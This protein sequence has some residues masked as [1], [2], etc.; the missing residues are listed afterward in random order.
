MKYFPFALPI[1]TFLLFVSS[2]TPLQSGSFPLTIEDDSG[3]DGPW[4]IVAG[5][6]FPEGLTK[7][8]SAMRIISGGREVP[9]QMDVAATW[10]DGSIRW[11]LAGFTASPQ[12]QYSVEYGEGVK[13]GEYPNPL[14]VI[15]QD[16][17]GF[18]VD[19]GAAVYRFESD[20]ILPEEGWIVIAGRREKILDGSGAGVYLV[21]NK[22]RTARIAGEAAEVK[23]EFLK[24]GPGRLVLKRSGWYVTD[25]GEKLARADVWLYF[26]SGV[27]Y[28]RAT[29]TLVF[30]EDTNNVWFKDYGLEFKTPYSPLQ[31][32]CAVGEN[33]KEIHKIV[34]SGDE[35]YLLQAEYPHFAEREY[36]AAI[37]SMKNGQDSVMEEIKEVGDWAYGDY[38][39]YGISIVMPWLAERYPKEIS[40]GRRGARAVFWSGRS[41][42]E[43]DFR[44]KT[45][46]EEYWQSWAEKGPGSPG[47]GKLSAF[48]SNAAGSARTHDIWFL[49]HAGAYNEE[50]VKK[51]ALAGSRQ[52]LAIAN[53]VWLCETEAMGYPMLHKDTERFPKQEAMISECWQRYMIPYKAFPLTGFIEW[54]DFSTWQYNTVGGRI[55]AQFHILTNIDR[56]SSRREPWRLFARSAERQYYNYGHRFSRFS[57]DWY[58]IHHDVAN[59]PSRNRGSFMSFTPEGGRL[60][61]AWG[62]TGHL[63]ITNGGDIGC[64]L[65]E[66]Y[67]T[68]DERS[69]DLL[70]MIKESFKKYWKVEHAIG[71]NQ[72]K[73]VRELVTLSIMDWDEDAVKMAKEVADSMF[74][75]ESQ[76][77]I[78][79][80]RDSYGTMYKDHRTSHNTAEYYLE[81]KDELAKQA[82]LKLM[83]QRYR[84]DRRYNP[85]G[86]KNYDGFTAS[87]AYWISGDERFRRVAEQTLQD[88]LYY[89]EKEPL[90]EILKKYPQNPLDWKGM[91]GYLGVTDWHSPFIGFPTALKLVSQKGW[92]GKRTPVVIK[93]SDTFAAKTIFRHEQGRDTRISFYYTT[94]RP[95]V[96]LEVFKYPES[97]GNKPV[98][99][100]H[101]ELEE[102][103]Q[104]PARLVV[105]PDDIY[106]AYITVP[107]NV[108]GGLYL[109]STG[110]NEPFTV[111]DITGDKAALYCPE[112]FRAA[113]GTP[114]QR[115]GEGTF[116][117]AGEGVPMFFRVPS[118]LEKLEIVL[119]ST[120]TIKR[121][122]GKTV[123]DA[124]RENT[125]MINIPVEGNGG[126][127]S[128][129][130]HLHNFKGECF[131]GF[132]RLLNVEPVVSFGS[133]DLLPEG[134]TGI[135]SVLQDSRYRTNEPMEFAEGISGKSLRLSNGKT[136]SFPLGEKLE[137]GGYAHFPG[138]SGTVEFWFR[139]DYSTTEKTLFAFTSTYMPFIRGPHISFQ[140]KYWSMGS[141][142]FVFSRLQLALLTEKK[143]NLGVYPGY[144]SEYFFNAGE[145][146]HIAYTWDIR[147]GE[148][149]TE[150]A[151]AIFVNGKKQPFK[152]ASYGLY[153]LTGKGKIALDHKAENVVIGPFDGSIDMLRLSDNVRYTK[154]F[155]PSGTSMKV[156]GNTRALFQFD[157]T[158][159]GESSFSQGPIEMK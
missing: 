52:V 36:R 27:P 47:K 117:R 25:A 33:G 137:Q 20:R 59:S 19:T 24:E 29:H 58:L 91:P 151:L 72:S 135:A 147:E 2:F 133:P 55:M 150:G 96:K 44:G 126:I 56:Y 124:S 153:Q 145:W 38:G 62:Q 130:P 107:S 118:G 5:I 43:L 40:F 48:A 110:G 149:G 74:D 65:L 41:G 18:T 93:S 10:R 116:G 154:D 54:G 61:F 71:V 83:D 60:P 138:L 7:D 136:I 139:A 45:L 140:Q 104:W 80:F 106:H 32:Y 125:G 97:P 108:T 103:M 73:V 49:P 85:F 1:I 99:D 64:W 28:I 148:K 12:G 102:R 31:A 101:V 77:G 3:L 143:D 144:Q 8:A 15:R 4:P 9:S 134:T 109:L 16:D 123:L 114:I 11:A 88:A 94:L 42:K 146:T 115:S 66:Y 21:D 57:G 113:S 119:A 70:K 68:G 92:S 120:A 152:S 159:K 128:I 129:E 6:P 142:R 81:T 46:V 76:N 121:P 30:T 89:I 141:A 105:R 14:R 157:G 67:L 86:H 22:G 155:L 50:A 53:P 100:I 69:L 75:L 90:S 78:R 37:G 34:N 51:T 131:P 17:G 82:F 87:I 35:I 26:S 156:D 122:D 127:W 63:Y 95:D 98:E 132:Y 23:N 112:G 84:F 111:L 158:L 13:M 79:M 39:S